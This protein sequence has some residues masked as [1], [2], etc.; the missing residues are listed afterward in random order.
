MILVICLGIL[1]KLLNIADDFINFKDI[2]SI[3]HPLT[4]SKDMSREI[5]DENT[6]GIIV[7]VY[8]LF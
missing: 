4:S 1:L 5:L 7:S 3:K 8:L 2:E 6:K